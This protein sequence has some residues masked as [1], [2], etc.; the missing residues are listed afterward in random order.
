LGFAEHAKSL[1][2]LVKEGILFACNGGLLQAEDT[3][4]VAG[5]QPHSMA[6]FEREV[7][8]EVR[9]CIK[10]AAFVGKW[11]ALSDDYT[12]VMALWR[13]RHEHPNPRYC[14]VF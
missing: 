2:P 8:D 11:V 12:T 13:W 5:R 7:T 4:I 10:K 1:A 14:S 6:Q 3:R 9:A